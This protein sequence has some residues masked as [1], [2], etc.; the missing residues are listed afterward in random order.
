MFYFLFLRQRLDSRSCSPI[1]LDSS[2]ILTPA[3]E[4][5]IRVRE[6]RKSMEQSGH[7]FTPVNSPMDLPITR[8]PGILS[9]TARNM[10]LYMTLDC[11]P[12]EEP[13][14]RK[15]SSGGGGAS[16]S[17]TPTPRRV[18]RNKAHE[19]VVLDDSVSTSFNSNSTADLSTTATPERNQR[20]TVF[21]RIK[22]TLNFLIVIT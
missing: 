4:E 18:L 8:T 20:R 9:S 19:S 11:T 10:D 14:R 5:V 6:I 3:M 22:T 15:K 12:E 17:G 2:S 13:V 21:R 7:F 1:D 16:S